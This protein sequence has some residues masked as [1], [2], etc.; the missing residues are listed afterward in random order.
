MA[1]EI[2]DVNDVIYNLY[3]KE[4]STIEEKLNQA[5]NHFSHPSHMFTPLIFFTDLSLLND[6]LNLTLSTLL[7][8]IP[9]Y[10]I[11]STLLY[12]LYHHIFKSTFAPRHLQLRY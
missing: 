3:R 8:A 5:S 9:L 4:M 10:F 6:Y 2:S 11:T 12:L 1:F 7:T